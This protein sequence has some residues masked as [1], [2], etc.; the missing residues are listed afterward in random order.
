MAGALAAGGSVINTTWGLPP[1]ETEQLESAFRTCVSLYEQPLAGALMRT[2]FDK[3]ER[4]TFA[5]V[6]SAAVRRFSIEREH[7][8]S[9][10][11]ARLNDGVTVAG[12]P[13][14]A[15]YASTCELECAL[16]VFG[17][18]FGE[19]KADQQH[20]LETWMESAPSTQTLA[21]GQIKVQLNTT[22][23][24]KTLLICDVSG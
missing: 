16:A 11:T 6:H 7:G 19:L 13:V 1:P 5:T 18:E 4:E 12:I 10:A 20:A 9:T 3:A 22:T 21:R 24:G 15:M 8:Y 23:D 17:L 2:I 14:Q